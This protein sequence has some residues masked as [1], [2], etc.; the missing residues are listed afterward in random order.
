MLTEGQLDSHMINESDY[1]WLK[2]YHYIITTTELV[3]CK[4]YPVTE[5]L[6]MLTLGIEETVEGDIR[7]KLKKLGKARLANASSENLGWIN[8]TNWEDK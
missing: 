2:L 8:G 4:G 1:E 5:V 6:A 3:R 7:N